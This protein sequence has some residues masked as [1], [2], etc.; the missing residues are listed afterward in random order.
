MSSSQRYYQR[1]GFQRSSPS[2]KKRERQNRDA[3]SVNTQGSINEAEASPTL[4]KGPKTLKK[5][6]DAH[7]WTDYA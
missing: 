3:H 6:G 2:L 4:Y 1:V 7:G 5:C